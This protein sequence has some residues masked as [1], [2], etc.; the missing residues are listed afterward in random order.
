MDFWMLNLLRPSSS[1]LENNV[2]KCVSRRFAK[3]CRFSFIH[4]F[5][6]ARALIIRFDLIFQLKPLHSIGTC[7]PFFENRNTEEE[8][9]LAQNREK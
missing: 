4:N 5:S 9:E 1:G 8:D 3:F 2:A 6:N 7:Q